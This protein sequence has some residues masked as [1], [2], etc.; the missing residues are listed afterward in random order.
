MSSI[1]PRGTVIP[2][3]KS[4]VFTTHSD[5][6][7]V[8]KIDVYE[9]ERTLVK[10]NHNLGSFDMTG[11][12]PAAKGVAKVEVTFQIDENSI[13]TVS[14]VDKGTGK[15]ETI[16]I[17]NGKS[18]LSK[19]QIEKMIKESEKYEKEDKAIRDR[20]EQINQLENYIHQMKSSI[21]DNQKLG[22]KISANDKKKIKEAITD[23]QDWLNSNPEAD[24][25]D[26]EEKLKDL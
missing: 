22:E 6:Q 25:D 21:E 19:E 26:V 23:T 16:T 8:I 4:S 3:K 15:K 13:L 1:I 12:P 17:T 10:D 24:K 20:I 2:A 14:A 9:G 11:I 18:R 7:T 5:Q